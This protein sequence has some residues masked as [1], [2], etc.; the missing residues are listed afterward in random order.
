MKTIL[1][2]LF[3]GILILTVSCKKGPETPKEGSMIFIR[4]TIVDTTSYYNVSVTTQVSNPGSIS[5][6]QHGH[7]WDTAAN[8]D[9]N[10]NHSSLGP[11]A[12][13]GKFSETINILNPGTKYYIRPYVSYTYGILYGQQVMATTLQSVLPTVTT[14]TITNIKFNAAKV[15]VNISSDGGSEVTKRGICWNTNGNPTLESCIGFTVDGTGAGSFIA[16]MVNLSEST[17]YYVASYATNKKGIAYSETKQVS[18][19]QLQLPTVATLNVSNVDTTSATC[20]G[21]SIFDGNGNVSVRGV[22]WNTNGNPTLENSIGFTADGSG[23]AAFTSNLTGLNNLTTYYVTAYATNEKGTYYSDDVKQFSTHIPCGTN[24]P[25]GG[26]NYQSV[27]IGT[28][29]WFKDNLNIGTRINGSQN[30]TDN[31]IT[32]KYCYDNDTNNCN[33]YGGLY[34][35][36]ELMQYVTT[37]GTK[38]L[39]PAG[40]HIPSKPEWT[41]LITFLEGETLAGGKMKE[42]GI[43]HWS[44]P[45]TGATNSSGFTALPGGFR[46]IDFPFANLW[47][48][49][50]FWSSSLY[51]SD[52]AWNIYLFYNFEGINWA[53][54][55]LGPDD[56]YSARCIQD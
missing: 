19:F 4:N 18:T 54:G 56:G 49:G 38:G 11:L 48:S 44:S 23:T 45:N 5:L 43:V 22:C 32:E 41:V 8:P 3:S 37:Q 50:L 7:C 46:S 17:A 1:L 20:G 35:W 10:G 21:N 29:C 40:W 39:C 12:N 51:S 27:Q 30:Q 53:T 2:G 47:L 42:A 16:S 52:R 13:P 26:K 25:H 28:Q 9:I 34:Q 36:N 33:T 24:V 6:Q 31:G 15:S 55:Y 14:L